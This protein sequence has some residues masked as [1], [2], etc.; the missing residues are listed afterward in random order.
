M[1]NPLLASFDMVPFDYIKAAHFLPAVESLIAQAK[2]D[3][4]QITLNKEPAN[5]E[6]TLLGL[7]YAGL[8][9]ERVSQCFFNLL[10][11]HTNDA[12]QAEA[13][14]IAP[15]LS[16]FKND[17]LMDAGLFKRIKA[18][19]DQRETCALTQEQ[20]R[21]LEQTYKSF[22]R[23]GA[24]LNPKQ[25]E[26]V[27]QIDS[28]LAKATLTFGNNVLSETNA[29]S[30]HIEDE[31]TLEGLPQSFLDSAREQARSKGLEGFILGLDF[32]SYMPVMKFAKNRALRQK[33]WLAYGARGAQDNEQDNKAIIGEIVRLRQRR[34]EI[35]GYPNHA[36]FVLEERMAKSPETVHAFLTDLSDKAR[37]AAERELNELQL[38]AQKQQQLDQLEP[39]DQAFYSEGLKTKLFDWDEEKIKA[40]FPLDKVLSGVFSIAKRLYGLRFELDP[41]VPVY[42]HEVKVYRV[43][44]A[45]S[46][47]K[48][49]LYTDF[50]P[51]PSKRDG[52]WMTSYKT[53]YKSDKENHRPH[54]SIVCNFTHPDDQGR[55]LLSFQEVTTL[56]HEFGHAL[57]GILADTQY[58]SLS[59][60]SVSWDFVELPSQI[61][62][63]WCCQQ[64]SLNLFAQH[65][66]TNEPLPLVYL[67]QINAIKSFQEG[68][69]TLRQIGFATLDMAYHN[70][71]YTGPDIV[72]FEREILGPMQL[73]KHNHPYLMSTAFSHIFQGGYAAGYYSYKWA[74]V[75]DADAFSLFE[76]RGIFDSET[77]QSFAQHILS[78]G[79]TQDPMILY[80]KFRGRAPKNEALL[81]RAGLLA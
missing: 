68:L 32:P 17:I 37:P 34:A 57:H 55:A 25:Q 39:W 23:N 61:M 50:H 19:Y 36:A 5:F 35:L 75:L 77:A 76:E 15:L 16:S 12:L 74:E 13:Q 20:D 28:A 9:L 52:A 31:E 56:F 46:N 58:P 41:S 42:H 66:Q 53:Q 79:G 54:I 1:T 21:L 43:L 10:S 63:N 71:Q 24:L 69:Q 49:L 64:E 6:N 27:R 3:I 65:Y 26:E 62:E 14:S 4:Q 51:R 60:T 2:A 45:K 67:E 33:L 29:F 59:G 7:E 72:S 40:Y 44:D 22:C 80:E 38:F 11:A 78:Q 73:L 30:L 48:A 8:K 18:L 81:R 70:G 47:F